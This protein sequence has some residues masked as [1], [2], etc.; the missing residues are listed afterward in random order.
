ME[1]N[2]TDFYPAPK[3]NIY[4]IFTH[5]MDEWVNTLKEANA[6]FQEWKNEYG[7]ARLWSTEW[8]SENGVPED[9][10]CLKSFGSFPW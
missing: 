3:G 6:L 7:S 2:A 5:E 4:H 8:D 9:K 1:R 10:D